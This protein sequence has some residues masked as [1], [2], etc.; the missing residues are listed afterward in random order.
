LSSKLI[1]RRPSLSGAP[2]L[3]SLMMSTLPSF[4]ADHHFLAG[5]R[6]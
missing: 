1:T 4:D 5:R 3:M 6:P 2:M